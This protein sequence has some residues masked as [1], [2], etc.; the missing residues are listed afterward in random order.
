MQVISTLN[1]EHRN[2]GSFNN[3]I[4]A[5]TLLFREKFAKQIS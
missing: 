2:C 1:D 4:I 5:E 3:F